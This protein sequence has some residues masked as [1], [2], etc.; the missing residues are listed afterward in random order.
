[1]AKRRMSMDVPGSINRQVILPVEVPR[2]MREDTQKVLTSFAAGKIAPLAFTPLYRE[3]AVRSGNVAVTIEML[4]TAQLLMNAVYLNLQVHFVPFSAFPRFNGSLDIMNRSYMGEPPL[5]GEAVIPFIDTEVMGTFDDSGI[6][7]V[8]GAHAEAGTTVNTAYIEAYNLTVNY[9]RKNRSPALAQR[10]LDDHTLAPAFWYH[11]NF[12]DIV[13]DFD[14]GML[15]GEVA[16]NVV[17][18]QMPIRGLGVLQGATAGGSQNVTETGDV[19]STWTNTF[20][21][22]NA[23]QRL[24]AEAVNNVP[25][26]FAELADNGI[27]ISL[28]NIELARKTQAFAK[29]RERYT[30]L[31]ET[32]LIDM[33]MRGLSIPDQAYRFP[34]H[35][36]SRVVPFMQ[37]KRFS[38]TAGSM[39]DTAV[40]GATKVSIPVRIPQVH[41]GGILMVTAEVT[42]EQLWERKKDYF[43]HSTDVSEFPDYLRD[44]LDPQKVDVVLNSDVDTAHATPNGTFGY[45]R[46]NGHLNGVSYRVGGKFKRP[47]SGSANDEDRMRI[48]A[49]ETANPTLGTDF[50]LATNINQKPFL[51]TVADPFEA[52]CVVQLAIE[53]NTQ[54]GPPLVES[55]QNY[56]AVLAVAPVDRIEP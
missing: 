54:F 36:G 17:N 14:P 37:A 11:Q 2:T 29:I 24:V 45:R 15:E 49:A 7:H 47:S 48:W 25:Q 8:A 52:V 13:P 43:L 21:S 22:D 55:E 27:T 28:A 34:M 3:D 32:F 41:T 38:T 19:D 20:S 9:R 44:Y 23:A 5:V 18:S 39:D 16:L 35:V 4:E 6:Y 10:D 30:E 42:P 51:D 40:N 56:D 53:G 33:L 50:Y 1:M 46:M 12:N 26:I 31:P